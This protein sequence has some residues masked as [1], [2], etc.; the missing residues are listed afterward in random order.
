L[1]VV[2]AAELKMLIRR[3]HVVPRCLS[4]IVL[5]CEILTSDACGYYGSSQLTAVSF[6]NVYPNGAWNLQAQQTAA[7]FNA[8]FDRPSTVSDSDYNLLIHYDKIY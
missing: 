7:F 1:V 4:A 2:A 3:L 6:A 5:L 8:T